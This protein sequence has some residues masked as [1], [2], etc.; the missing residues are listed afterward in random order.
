[1]IARH[2][3]LVV[4][5][6]GRAVECVHYGSIAVT[7]A[8]GKLVASVGDPLAVTF[9]R[10]ALKPFQALPL[11]ED[12]GLNHFGLDGR[13]LAIMCASHNAEPVHIAIVRHILAKIGA[14][15]S[16][17]CCG[18]RAPGFYAAT[19][20]VPPRQRW[21][22]LCHN[23]SGK[24]AGFLAWCRLH[25]RPLREYLD[26]ASPLQRRIRATLAHL[27]TGATL[28][29]GTDGCSAPNYALPLRRIAQLY[30]LLASEAGGALAIVRLAMTRYPKIVSGTGRMD[31]ALMRAG[32]GDW[33][34]KGGAAGLQAIGVRSR[35]LGIAVRI[36]D[37]NREALNTATLETLHQLGLLRKADRDPLA[38]FARR[39]VRN[40]MGTAVGRIEAEFRLN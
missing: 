4:T 14:H 31:L 5:I 7:D 3:P 20:R 11:V 12:G 25:R 30:G 2:V 16:D 26:P 15:V 40:D 28:A 6:R 17:L 33:V 32:M 22:A 10:S 37:G 19:G 35:S 13:A 34:A 39:A 36:A 29:R 8:T 18:S 21:S 1:M 9:T 24:H 23:C 27:A 38:H